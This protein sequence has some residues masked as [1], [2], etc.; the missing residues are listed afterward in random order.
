[1]SSADQPQQRTT[2]GSRF[3][4]ESGSR[5]PAPEAKRFGASDLRYSILIR[6]DLRCGSYATSLS[7]TRPRNSPREQSRT[8]LRRS[9]WPG[10]APLLDDTITIFL[11]SS[12]LRPA[13][14]RPTVRRHACVAHTPC[15]FN[16]HRPMTRTAHTAVG[17][18][19]RES[20]S[21]RRREPDVSS[22]VRESGMGIFHQL[23][24]LL[25]RVAPQDGAF[26]YA[27]DWAWRLRLP[28]QGISVPSWSLVQSK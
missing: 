18:S 26:C 13:Y 24:V 2:N 25:D 19:G 21:K 15:C 23:A 5:L 10:P 14:S 7:W 3:Q 27:L 16:Q 6:S 17:I 8:E 4:W 11:V 1:M 28:V 9:R 20:K 12:P 22:A